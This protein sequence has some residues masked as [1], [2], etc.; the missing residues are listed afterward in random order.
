VNAPVI[1]HRVRAVAIALG[2]A[3]VVLAAMLAWIAG[4]EP[5]M[6]WGVA[7]LD[8]LLPGSLSIGVA[9]GRIR[10]PFDLHDV[11]Y[12]TKRMYVHVAHVHMDWRL[13]WLANRRL[14]IRTL[15]MDTVDVVMLPPPEMGGPPDTS[16]ALPDVKL[17]VLV[18]VGQAR[19]RNIAFTAI[20]ADTA[21]RIDEVLLRDGAFRDSFALGLLSVR[22]PEGRLELRGGA[23]A[24]GTYAVQLRTVWVVTPPGGRTFAGRGTIEGGIDSLRVHQ[25]LAQPFDGT[26]D[27]VA[28]GPRHH[29]VFQAVLAFADLDPR[30][31]SPDLPA[32]RAHGRITLDGRPAAFTSTGTI[33]ARTTDWGLVRAV[34]AADRDTSGLRIH[35]VTITR[36]GTP[37]RLVAQGVVVSVGGTQRFHMAGTWRDVVWPLDGRRPSVQSREGRFAVS[38]QPAA[39]RLTSDAQVQI[40]AVPAS[41]WRVAG[42]GD[43][44]ELRLTTIDGRPLGG[45]VTGTGRLAWGSSLEWRFALRGDH[46]D[47]GT[48]W[49]DL[50]GSLAFTMRTDGHATRGGPIG[51]VNVERFAGTLR[52][53][54]LDGHADL[55]LVP[56]GMAI[57]AFAMQWGPDSVAA[58]GLLA[59]AWD[60]TWRVNAPDLS[61]VRAGATGSLVSNGRLGGSQ[62]APRV[63]GSATADSVR[64]GLQALTHM[65]AVA[66]VDLARGAKSKF[67]GELAGVHVNGHEFAHVGVHGAGTRDD[68]TLT[69]TA[70]SD[71][72]SARAALR[73][74]YTGG[75]WRGRLNEL[76]LDSQDYGAWRLDSTGAAVE[77]SPQLVA[78][79]GVSWG[80]GAQRVRADG[81]WTPDAWTLSSAIEQLQLALL[82]PF[83]PPGVELAGVVNGR[84]DVRGDARGATGDGHADVAGGEISFPGQ[85][86]QRTKV[87]IET[88]TMRV[89]ARPDA[90]ESAA[91]LSF[92]AAGSADATVRMRPLRFRAGLP[93]TGIIGG[94][95]QVRN[96][97]FGL[98]EAVLPDVT[99]AHGRVNADLRVEGTRERPRIVGTAGIDGAS[100]F[101][102]RF[103]V[104]V[105][106]LNVTGRS[107]E[108][109]RLVLHGA[110][111]SGPGHV[112]LEGEGLFGASGL[113]QARLKLVGDRFEAL[114]AQGS[115]VLAS[116]DVELVAIA[117]SVRVTGTVAVPEADL[118]GF[119]RGH[120]ALAPSGDVVF[121]RAD[122]SSLTKRK[123]VRLY[124]EMRL[125]LGD[126]VRLRAYG[127]DAR[128]LGG[129]LAYARPD[130]PVT[131]SGELYLRDGGTYKAYGQTL[132]I[133][134]GRL[135]FAGGPVENP[136]L[137]VRA[138]RT[139]ND[140]TVA[141]F[142]VTGTLETPRMTV[143]SD[144]VMADRDALA[145]VLF[146]R[147]MDHAN[148][149]ENG[150]VTEAA[151]QLGIG[152]GS[153]IASAIGRE[154]GLQDVSIASDNGSLEQSSLMLGT[155][156]S[157][158]LYVNYG[159]GI[160]DPASTLRI[161]YFVNNRWTLMAET[162]TQTRADVLFTVEH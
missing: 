113:P 102:P 1:R 118:R 47:P 74:A 6:R 109:G 3:G 155:Y 66:D 52:E 44:K 32:A 96:L 50:P 148:Q 20:G 145:Y 35:S 62:Y 158:R 8:A 127:L 60:L 89:A 64:W 99:D 152:G 154:L 59:R 15:D 142:E 106:D 53:H 19:A 48:A 141:G 23:R 128:P 92:G 2:V 100:A 38:G 46:I 22:A 54:P 25:V 77:A 73:G 49:R 114:N 14:D 80:S 16:T 108:L 91:A 55:R 133:E 65:D 10:G 67:D 151:N 71:I 41:R 156:V 135:V 143:F 107:D 17:P 40:A 131:G 122:S 93:P 132:S 88:A 126:Q 101:V 119:E 9:R 39:Y 36:P 68:H 144:P 95:L 81:R 104:G 129:V 84:L 134:R 33:D 43:A 31:F 147:R 157:P 123:P 136:G 51:T 162:G 7:R 86:R 161:Q 61:V 140:G 124:A 21:R 30:H 24:N 146:G 82:R 150:V 79:R 56:G 117:D 69:A 139:A 115:H 27:V 97:D 103:G 12:E 70:S 98:A 121:V 5:G 11:R 72:D 29:T 45:A 28:H 34:Y 138:S 26:L 87:P 75:G 78:V 105:H 18:T 110:A 130:R 120:T 63:A 37:A 85:G 76:S 116:P 94:T 112:S 83:V 159:M 160:T 149:N 111:A 137:D 90:I 153:Y 125:T 58:S 13:R 42:T 57:P 4:T